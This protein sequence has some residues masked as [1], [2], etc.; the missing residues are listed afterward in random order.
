LIASD[1]DAGAI[2]AAL[3]NAERA[4]VA[5]CIDFSCRSLSAVK[6]PP[7]PGWIVTNPPYGVRVS[8][9][10]DLRNLYAQ[11]GKVLRAGCPGWNIAILCGNMTLLRHSGLV[12]DRSMPLSNGGLRIRFATGK[13]P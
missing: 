10:R 7:V 11:I 4:G 12:F 3:A 9:H 8:A 13:I 6:P 5:D 1:R 2:R